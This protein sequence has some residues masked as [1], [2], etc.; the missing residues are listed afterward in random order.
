VPDI[1]AAHCLMVSQI[2]SPVTR[3]ALLDVKLAAQNGIPVALKRQVEEVAADSLARMPNL[4]DDLVG[5][6]IDVF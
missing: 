2:G 1:A 6:K 5:G 4:V 3:P